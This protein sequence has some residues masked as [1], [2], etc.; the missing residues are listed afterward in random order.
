MPDVGIGDECHFVSFID[1]ATQFAAAIPIRSRD[2]IDVTL[3]NFIRDCGQ[4]PR[5]FLSDNAN[6]YVC[7][8]V[9]TTVEQYGCKSVPT[10]TYSPE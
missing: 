7:A 8:L 1:V 9:H 10:S 5:I 3:S 2:E 4:A 6:E